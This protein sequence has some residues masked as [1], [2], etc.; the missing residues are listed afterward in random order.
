[1]SDEKI[2]TKGLL[3][4][5]DMLA[6]YCFENEEKRNEWIS[7][8]YPSLQEKYP[9]LSYYIFD[10]DG[11]EIGDECIVDGE[12]ADIFTIEGMK[13]YSDDRYGFLMSSGWWEEVVKCHKPIDYKF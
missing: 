6:S 9:D 1:M 3:T 7:C 5:G 2:F 8:I 13:K 11:L 4:K 10:L 12:G